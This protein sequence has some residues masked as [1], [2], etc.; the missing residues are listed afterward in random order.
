[1]DLMQSITVLVCAIIVIYT[2]HL[3]VS[4]FDL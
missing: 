3:I 4:M 2:I 1:M